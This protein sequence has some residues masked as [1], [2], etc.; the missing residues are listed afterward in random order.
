M[1]KV[2]LL[3]CDDAAMYATM[4]SV[5]LRDDPAIEVIGVA[6]D[7]DE[8]LERATALRPDVVLLD[9]LME[10]VDSSVVAPRLRR[11]TP[12]STIVLTSGAT[13]DVL[14][15][16]ADVAGAEGWVAK[17]ASPETLRER[18]LAIRSADTAQEPTGEDRHRPARPGG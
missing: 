6:S 18:I 1:A 16:A 13:D 4:L 5:W 2:T 3:I 10:G 8:A 17:A 15:R 7:I 11:C 14:T 9:H 12:G